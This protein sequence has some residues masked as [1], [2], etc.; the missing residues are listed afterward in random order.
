M[1]RQPFFVVIVM[2]SSLPAAEASA[3]AAATR[4]SPKVTAAEVQ[5]V[6]TEQI[7]FADAERILRAAGETG[8]PKLIEPLKSA[9]S[10]WAKQPQHALAAYF[11][12]HSLW[13]LGESRDY[14][15]KNLDEY[16]GNKWLA[17]YSIL[18]LGRDPNG[19]L[20][21]RLEQIRADTAATGDND[22]A[23]AVSAVRRTR[24][25]IE[26]YQAMQAIAQRIDLLL[27][28]AGSTWNPM[29][30]MRSDPLDQS[31]PLPFWARK[32]LQRLSGDHEL[33]IAQRLAAL[34][35]GAGFGMAE[36]AREYVAQFLPEKVRK[37]YHELK[38]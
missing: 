6:A 27:R 1:C 4:P 25:V 22:L 12:L 15:L 29:S 31:S 16:K 3:S 37:A 7:S 19:S 32:E 26:Q 8:D 23:A 2:V 20:M 34:D 10:T 35:I 30:G 28:H 17:Y 18:I 13:Q 11:A 14:F 9:A 21:D 24:D 5:R 36:D 33:L 38:Q